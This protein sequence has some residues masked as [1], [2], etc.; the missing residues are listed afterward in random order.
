MN[1]Y[2]ILKDFSGHSKESGNKKS[3]QEAIVGV[4]AEDYG[5]LV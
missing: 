5:R 3:R 4:Q 1:R 2:L